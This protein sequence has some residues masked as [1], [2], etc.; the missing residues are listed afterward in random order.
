[1]VISSA[2]FVGMWGHFLYQGVM[3]PLGGIYSLWPLFGISNQLLAT[4]ALCVATTIIIKMGKARYVFVTMMP[5][6]WLVIVTMTAGYQKI[7]STDWK[8]GF[9]AHAQKWSAHLAA[10][11]LPPGVKSIPAAERMIFN[12]YMDAGVAAFFMV[13][14]IV[15][16]TASITEWLAVL[17]GR[18][19]AVSTETPMDATPA[20]A[21][22]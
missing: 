4:V 16:L 8:L 6:T 21:G 20:F 12:D 14:V 18:K 1:V 11:E 2:I 7:F 17:Q 3:D 19:P 10:G 22:D 5:L 15:I 13:A 9:V